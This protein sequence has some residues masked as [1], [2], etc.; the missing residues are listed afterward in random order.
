MLLG[1]Y[2]K[3]RLKFLAKINLLKDKQNIEYF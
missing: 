2:S 3:F 1:Y